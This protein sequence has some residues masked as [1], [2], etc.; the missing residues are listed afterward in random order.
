[1]KMG[2]VDRVDDL[3]FKVNFSGDGAAKLK[4]RVK[5]KLKE[6]MG[7]YTDDTLVEYVIVLLRNGRR[8]DEAMNELNVFLGDDSDSFVSWL[9]DHLASNLDLYAPSREPHLDEGTRT[10]VLGNQSIGAESHLLDTDSERGKSTKFPR[11]RHN[12]DWKGLVRDA[13]EPPPLRSSEVENIR[14]EEKSSRKVSRGRSTSPRPTQKKRSRPD[15]RQPIKREAVPQ[16]N[17][18]A[19]RR[20]LQF[21]VRDAVGTSRAPI[22]AKEPSSKRLR[23]VVSTSSGELPA[24][25]KRIQSVAR[26]PNP[27]ATVIKAV[28]EAAEDVTK[29]KNAGSVFDR[30]GPGMDVLETRDLHPEFRESLTEDEEYG[31]LNQPLEKTHSAYYQREEYAGRHV[32]NVTA[33]ESQTGL[34][35]ESLSDNEWYGDVDVVGH[36]V[37]DESHTGHTGRSGGNKGDNSLMVQ[38]NVA[39][40]D[41]IL[42]T[43]NKDQNQ[44]TIATNTSRKIVNISVNV[45]TWKPPHYQEAREVSELDG[46][47]SLPESEAV[48]NKANHRLMENGN[49]VNV[50]NGNVKGAAY[51][52]ELSQKAVQPSSASYAA[53]RPLEDADSRTIFVSN[54]HFAATKDSLSRHFNK[55]GDVL[56]V[57][58]VTDA[59]T[60]QPKGSAYVEFIRKEAADNA[61]SLDGTSFMSRILK[62]VKKSSAPQEAAAP[63]MTWPRVARGSPFVAARFGRASFARGMP[64]AFRPHLPIKPGARSFQ[65]KRDAQTTTTPTDAVTG[66]NISSPTFRSLTYVRTEPKSEGNAT[67]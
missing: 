64:G 47:K 62:V 65:W 9:W 19:P 51:D 46:R 15:D 13:A 20:L 5:E 35:S 10:T 55:F 67:R 49:P 29:V 33:L 32:G 54:V 61:L 11:N 17:I 42:Q 36:G 24:R 3:T 40:D 37:M 23:S 27:M 30:L 26:V 21:A 66:T 53:A 45:N 14:F 6:F 31:D 25:P 1:M 18:D 43:R 4:D 8:K 59:A 58:I 28:A 7:D 57:I 48:A 12:R 56:K 34:A 39:K 50:G 38:Y 41:E 16:M 22:S 52:Q 2:S 63:V 60:G 44:S